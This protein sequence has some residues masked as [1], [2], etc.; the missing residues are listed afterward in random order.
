MFLLKSPEWHT[1]ATSVR[2]RIHN[3]IQHLPGRH[4]KV[5][6][7]KMLQ[8]AGYQIG[9]LCFAL[10]HRHFIKY[11]IFWVRQLQHELVCVCEK[12]HGR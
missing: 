10:L 11:H 6:R 12:Q 9:I 7:R 8:I 4:D 1:L 2:W 3:D 5:F